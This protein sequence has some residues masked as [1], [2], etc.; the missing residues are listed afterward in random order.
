MK[1][2]QSFI[3]SSRVYMTG[4]LL[5]AVVSANAQTANVKGMVTD[6]SGEP[7]IGATV[8]VKGSSNIGTVTNMDGDFTLNGVQKGQTLIITYIGCDPQ[9]VKYT[10]QN[11]KIVMK[12]NSQSLN[13]IVVVG[14]GTQKKAN[15]SSGCRT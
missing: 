1:K 9:E 12:D 13:E 4:L 3:R 10:G 15:L 2:S 5:G 11:L 6:S 7:V 8:K 14:Y